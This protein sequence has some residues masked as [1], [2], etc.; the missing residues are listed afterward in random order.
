M[1]IFRTWDWRTAGSS[2]S[3]YE[4]I[5]D[6]EEGALYGYCKQNEMRG[7]EENGSKQSSC[8]EK[9]QIP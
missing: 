9:M 6:L 1:E 2:D 5:N 3:P 4:I 8:I 7:A